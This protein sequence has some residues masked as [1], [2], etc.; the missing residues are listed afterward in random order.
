MV[1]AVPRAEVRMLRSIREI[2]NFV[3]HSLPQTRCLDGIGGNGKR[4]GHPQDRQHRL[5]LRQPVEGSSTKRGNLAADSL[6]EQQRALLMKPPIEVGIEHRLQMGL[7]VG[8][9][10]LCGEIIKAP[11]Q[12]IKQWRR[13]R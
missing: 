3:Q 1:A 4:M 12:D 7:A 2:A 8:G 11:L 6:Q 10:K 13:D 5:R 9:G